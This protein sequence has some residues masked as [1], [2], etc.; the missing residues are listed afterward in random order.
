MNVLLTFSKVLL[1]YLEQGH[2]KLI[3]FKALYSEILQG[4]REIGNS[5]SLIKLLEEIM[6]VEVSKDKLLIQDI[7]SYGNFAC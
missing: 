7:I 2:Q 6:H 3:S 1:S 5:I 4:F